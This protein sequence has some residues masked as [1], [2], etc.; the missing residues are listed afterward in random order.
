M[1]VQKSNLKVL[2]WG[3]GH[4]NK[5][6]LRYLH[7]K[8]HILVGVIG[9]HNAGKDSG[10]VAGFSENG[11]TISS[12]EDA[13]RLIQSTKPDACILATRSTINDIYQTVLIL[14]RNGANTITIAEEAF[15]SWNTSPEKTKEIDELFKK[16]NCTFS[17]TGMQDIF[18]G[19]LPSLLMGSSHTVKK[20]QGLIQYNVDDYG[21]AL[22]EAHGV[23]LNKEEFA[24]NIVQNAFP[25]Y[26]WNSNEW[27]CSKMNWKIKKTSQEIL[28]MTSESQVI[29]KSLGSSIPA[30][31]S[32]GLKA[33]VTT[34]L[35]NGIVIE[36]HMI[37]QV[38]HGDMVDLCAWNISGEPDTEL[39]VKRPD[40]VAITC[41]TAVNRL[42]QIVQ[43]RAGYVTT[44][45][46]GLVNL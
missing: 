39:I 23:G 37:G 19:Y 16:N 5:V 17:G 44:D 9:H 15:Y 40:T 1:S 46:M 35:V 41:A 38:Y 4:M 12:H 14:G 25:S 28:S 20:I 18:W 43:A 29:S 30:G 27:I 7:E 42:S 13:E 31:N 26:V 10:V 11:V 24:I 45:E 3:F 33:I 32:L 36:T 21:R 2:L 34:E 6:I 8:N 22:C